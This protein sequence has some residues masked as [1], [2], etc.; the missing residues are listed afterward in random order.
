[1][2][3]IS[4][5]FKGKKIIEPN[6]IK[7]RPLKD[8]TKESIFNIIEHSNKFNLNL[9]ESIILDLFSGV[10]SFGIE[11]LS[12]G[13]KKVVFIENYSGVL[14]ILKKN[15]A[16]LKTMNNYE[17]LERDIYK[18][19]FQLDFNYKFN[20]IFLDP[21]YADKNINE[22][23]IKIKK[24]E[25]LDDN[26]IIIIH[27]HKNEKVFFSSGFKIIEEKKYGVSKIFFISKLN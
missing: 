16:N 7:T 27:R 18:S 2:R 15:L 22:L 14:P 11:C 6:N 20:L 25:L 13:S 23:L 17:I 10:G 21:P 8:L 12:R 24:S 5:L 1:M 19:N 3:I 4:G 9:Q 26:G